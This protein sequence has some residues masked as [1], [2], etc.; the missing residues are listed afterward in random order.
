MEIHHKK[1]RLF[2]DFFLTPEKESLTLSNLRRNMYQHLNPLAY[3]A[4]AT[5]KRAKCFSTVEF[6]RS[7]VTFDISYFA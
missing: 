7:K 4:S 2:Q 1:R 3:E 6:L 5:A